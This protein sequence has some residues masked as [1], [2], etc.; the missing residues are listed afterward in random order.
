[1]NLLS[2]NIRGGG[3]FSKRKR[4]SFLIQSNNIDVCFVQETKLSDFNDVIAGSFWGNKEVDWTESHS[5]G[6]SGGMVIL[7]RQGCFMVN[8]SFTG[9]GYVGINVT[10]KG[11]VYN[12]VNV[13][14]SCNRLERQ[15]LWDSLISIKARSLNEE[16]VVVGDFNEVLCKEE[17]IGVDR[18]R[19]WRGMEEFKSFVEVM[20][21]IDINCV[22]GKFTWYKDNGKAMSRLDRF[23]LSNKLIEVWEVV[24]QRIEKRDISDHTPIRLN[25]GKI[26]WGPKPF[27]FNNSWLKHEDFKAFMAKEWLCLEIRGRGDF[28]LIEKLKKLKDRLRVWNREVFGWIDLRVEE[29]TEKINTIDKVLV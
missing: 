24:D 10:W 7:W 16:W 4:V 3:S 9:R 15:L 21:L 22:G 18:I 28:V 13:Y 29:D 2:F 27:C 11:L 19:D 26:D 5:K 20:E 8:Y 6:A 23:L 17:R 1:M 14:A 25:V 12:M